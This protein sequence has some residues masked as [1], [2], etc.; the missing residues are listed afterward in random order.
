MKIDKVHQEYYSRWLVGN[1]RFPIHP[2]IID[3]KKAEVPL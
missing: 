3:N 1:G 2:P